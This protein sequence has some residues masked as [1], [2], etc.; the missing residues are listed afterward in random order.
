MSFKKSRIDLER[1]RFDANGNMGGDEL[2]FKV[3]ALQNRLRPDVGSVLTET[4]VDKLMTG[5]GLRSGLRSGLTVNV[6]K[7][8]K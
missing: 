8:K 5:A 7:E 2:L 4:E 3:V 1:T 6:R